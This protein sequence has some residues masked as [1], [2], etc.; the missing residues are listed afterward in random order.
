MITSIEW[1]DFSLSP[2]WG[3]TEG[4]NGC[5]HCDM[6]ARLQRWKDGLG[7]GPGVPRLPMVNFARNATRLDR[8]AVRGGSV[9]T[10]FPSMCDPFDEEV[11]IEWFAEF[12]NVALHT[13]HL[14]WLLLTKRPQNW[15]ARI[16]A[17]A[18]H[19]AKCPLP[20]E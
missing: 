6:M 4:S 14:I 5:R 19:L 10:V 2:W 9:K 17:A 8:K 16:S 20:A 7:C 13:R 11:P 12:L 18:E 15:H 3:C 1:T